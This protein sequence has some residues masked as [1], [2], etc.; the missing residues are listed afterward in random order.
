MT[1]G[2]FGTITLNIQPRKNGKNTVIKDQKQAGTYR[3]KC[4]R[5]TVKTDNEDVIMAHIISD[6][7]CNAG[8]YTDAERGE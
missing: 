6:N 7:E 4:S 5:C 1:I 8:Y 2:A 3:F